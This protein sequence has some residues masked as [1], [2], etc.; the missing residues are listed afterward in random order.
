MA[1]AQKVDPV[2]K[3]AHGLAPGRRG[4]TVEL[5][6]CMDGLGVKIEAEIEQGK[7][8]GPALNDL[9]LLHSRQR[10]VEGL[11]EFVVT[12]GGITLDWR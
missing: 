3:R 4:A 6:Q 11:V 10:Q 5:Y 1:L 9:Y 12:P 2:A 8:S 7:A